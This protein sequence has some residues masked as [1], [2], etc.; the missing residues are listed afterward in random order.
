MYCYEYE[1]G[2]HNIARPIFFPKS[3]NLGVLR[4]WEVP[5]AFVFVSSGTHITHTHHHRA[6]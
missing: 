4:G 1:I 5:T 2:V 6:E 3:P